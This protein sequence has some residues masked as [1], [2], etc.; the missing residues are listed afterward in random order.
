MKHCISLFVWLLAAVPALAH[1]GVGIVMDSR[2]NVF[3]TDLKHV[4][5]IAPDGRKSI[6]VAN[7][8]THELSLDA[9]DNL[10]G[11]HLWYEGER[12]DKWG[13]RVWRLSREGKLTD[14]IP[15]RE[16]F[17]Q[18]YSFVRDRAGNM[19]WAEGR[20]S[21]RI[22]KRA[23]D[24]STST[25]ATAELQNVRWMTATPEGTIFLID[26]Y[27]LVRIDPDG[28]VRVVAK[29]LAERSL[30]QF[31]VGDQ[32]AVYGLWPD[33]AG[34]VYVAVYGGRVVK[35]VSPEG[36]VTVFARSRPPWSPTG[37]LVAPNDDIWLLEYSYPF[38]GSARVRR[39]EPNGRATTF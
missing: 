18:N 38:L 10:Y 1:P 6:A 25:V 8:H 27:D 35:K 17:R 37:G 24:G 2:G 33:A 22:R 16:G 12:T 5:K 15:A 4:W 9:Q 20:S 7:V 23:P 31:F 26:L 11:E 39:F 30:W 28:S 14:I 19:Y 32:H 3:Y 34:N 36:R 29:N 21:T 13:H